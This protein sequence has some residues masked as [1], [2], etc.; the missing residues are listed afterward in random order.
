MKKQLT[1]LFL[2]LFVLAGTPV[3]LHADDA[4]AAPAGAPAFAKGSKEAKEARKVKREKRKAEREAKKAAHAAK[5]AG[6]GH[7]GKGRAKHAAT[8]PAAAPTE[9]AK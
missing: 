3:I 1:A 4:A 9:A 7:K 2:G 5:K 6:K 8:A